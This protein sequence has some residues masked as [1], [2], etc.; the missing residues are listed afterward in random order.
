MGCVAVISRLYKTG[1][2]EFVAQR[3]GHRVGV[4]IA[5][6]GGSDKG[7]FGLLIREHAGAELRGDVV[8]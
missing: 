3:L 1:E 2:S 6:R 5:W 4:K 8:S 7:T